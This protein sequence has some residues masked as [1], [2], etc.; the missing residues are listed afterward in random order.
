L[1]VNQYSSNEPND[2]VNSRNGYIMVMNDDST[3]NTDIGVIIIIYR[4]A[5]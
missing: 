3:I 4:D 2:W 5:Q 1:A